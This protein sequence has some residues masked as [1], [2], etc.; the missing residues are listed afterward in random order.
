MVLYN[1][2]QSDC[3]LKPWHCPE[4]PYSFWRKQN[5]LL[6]ENFTNMTSFEY[7]PVYIREFLEYLLIDV[8]MYINIM[9]IYFF[10]HRNVLIFEI[11]ADVHHSDQG[12]LYYFFYLFWYLNAWICTYINEKHIKLYQF[13]WG[14]ILRNVSFS[15][16]YPEKIF[17]A[18]VTW[19]MCSM[20]AYLTTE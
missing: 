20:K 17:Y 16:F 6:V 18:S 2:L 1:N 3:C 4:N 9:K 19:S 10:M 14:K 7:N 13:T 8:L 12:E 15:F 5:T 11:Y